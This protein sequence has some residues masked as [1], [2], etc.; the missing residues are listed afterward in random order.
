MNT[1]LPSE[2]EVIAAQ[3]SYESDLERKNWQLNLDNLSLKGRAETLEIK[4]ERMSPTSVHSQIRFAERMAGLGYNTER[5]EGS[6]VSKMTQEFW[7]CWQAALDS[8]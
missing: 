8:K 2:N 7:E 5:F 4:I 1:P 6:F 3:R